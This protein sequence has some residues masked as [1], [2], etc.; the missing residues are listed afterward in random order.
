VIRTV[1]QNSYIATCDESGSEYEYG[2][3]VVEDGRIVAVGAGLP[4]ELLAFSGG[5]KGA[6]AASAAGVDTT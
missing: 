6:Q 4:P 2:H 5:D 1:I 3:L